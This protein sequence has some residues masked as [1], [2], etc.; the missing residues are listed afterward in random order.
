MAVKLFTRMLVVVVF[1]DIILVTLSGMF[2]VRN[3]QT[4]CMHARLTVSGVL[5]DS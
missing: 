5:T 3:I 2:H 1:I 4:V